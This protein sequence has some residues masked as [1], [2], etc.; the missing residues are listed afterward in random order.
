M[1]TQGYTLAKNRIQIIQQQLIDGQAINTVPDHL[2]GA[3]VYYGRTTDATA[4]VELFISGKGGAVSEDGVTYFNRLYL[5][6]S[7]LVFGRATYLQY[8][9]TD[10][11]FGMAHTY[12]AVQNLNGTT[13]AP[14]DL[15]KDTGG[16][17]EQGVDIDAT[18]GD[19]DLVHFNGASTASITVDD[20]GDF[21]KVQ[22]TGIAAKTI[23]WKVV[24]ELFCINETECRNNFFFGDTAAQNSGD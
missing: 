19:V 9:Q 18:T 10:D 14:F 20:T 22:V 15:K 23:N 5:P 17:A 24:L 13:S 11:V 12:F 2:P 3:V 21:L 7:T 8:N 6:E 16:D 1:P 4:N